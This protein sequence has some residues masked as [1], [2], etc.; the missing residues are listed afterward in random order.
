MAVTN[1]LEMRALTSAAMQCKR[2]V[3][4]KLLRMQTSFLQVAAHTPTSDVTGNMGHWQSR[5]ATEK[6]N[7]QNVREACETE[8]Q[9]IYNSTSHELD[10]IYDDTVR[11]AHVACDAEVARMNERTALKKA[12]L[13]VPFD[14][15]QAPAFEA[16][17]ALDA[18]KVA[19]ENAKAALAAASDLKAFTT[20]EAQSAY[21]EALLAAEQARRE[22]IL[23]TRAEAE[24]MRKSA[25]SDKAQKS[26]AKAAE[27]G[28][29]RSRFR[30][31]RALVNTILR[32]ISTLTTVTGAALDEKVKAEV[33]DLAERLAC[34]AA[35]QH[36]GSNCTKV[37]SSGSTTTTTNTSASIGYSC[38]CVLGYGGQHCEVNHDQCA[39]TP[40][41]NGGN[42][43]GGV[44]GFSCVCAAGWSGSTCD[45]DIDECEPRPCGDHGHCTDK[46]NAYVCHCGAGYVGTNCEKHIDS[47]QT[48]S[49][50]NG[51]TCTNKANGYDCVCATGFTGAHCETEINSCTPINPC[52]NGGTCLDGA[53]NYMCTC[54][55]GFSGT[56]CDVAPVLCPPETAC[57]WCITQPQ[58][59][60]AKVHWTFPEKGSEIE[61][62]AR[63]EAAE[64]V[65]GWGCTSF[66]HWQGHC[67]L[68]E[69]PGTVSPSRA[70]GANFY[71][72][73]PNFVGK[74]CI[75]GEYNS[76]AAQRSERS[77]RS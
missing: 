54:L 75:E 37:N 8:A 22:T 3:R 36:G 4:I 63:C 67:W 50:A 18:A 64:S 27:C 34:E 65:V 47:C 69:P 17:A 60:C 35:C 23:H 30:E 40:C 73:V 49:C 10:T 44:N 42:C 32:H 14:A 21:D 6:G 70:H 57:K 26:A 68:C 55:G 48:H 71:E 46:V 62:L 77:E 41:K 45:T 9:G 76:T 59:V 31:E 13:K 20:D 39:L 11:R 58:G 66:T 2:A 16:Q 61:C 56:N 53:S 74:T 52:K 29:E 12:A 28:A 24:V 33:T 51:A 38:N 1:L 7:A 25:R 5:L 72:K 43:V 19:T 15:T